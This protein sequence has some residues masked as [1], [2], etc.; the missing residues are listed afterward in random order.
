MKQDKILVVEDEMVISMALNESLYELGYHKVDIALNAEEAQKCILKNNYDIVLMD[1]NLGGEVHGIDVMNS[2]KQP[3]N[4]P[5]LYLTGNS[6]SI[7]VDKAKQSNPNG[8]II[9]P[10]DET[11]LGI[12]IECVL[13][14]E[15]TNASKKLTAKSEI[16]SDSQRLIMRIGREG[17]LYDISSY[18]E[19]ITGKPPEYYYGKTLKS[20]DFE[21]FFSFTLSTILFEIIYNNK[22]VFYCNVNSVYFGQRRMEIAVIPDSFSSNKFGSF[23]LFFNDITDKQITNGYNMKSIDFKI[24]LACNNSSIISG[25]RSIPV[26]VENTEIVAEFRDITSL[27]SLFDPNKCNIMVLDIDFLRLKD[28]LAFF[29]KMQENKPKILIMAKKSDVSHL[30]LLQELYEVNG[31]FSK[32]ASDTTIR[33]AI[34]TVF[35]GKEFYDDA[36]IKATS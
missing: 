27:I 7:T 3:V 10:F 24:A 1:I 33:N 31:Y 28:T 35:E 4:V 15:K 11:E 23:L 36:L 5:F 8:F 6:D 2:V 29:S 18:V 13:H 12:N 9:K 16:N 26:F 17:Q 19:K 14:K 21:S 25:F 20:A 22:Q 34:I 32:T 30:K